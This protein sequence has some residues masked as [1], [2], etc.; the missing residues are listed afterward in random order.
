MPH[1]SIVVTPF[2]NLT[3]DPEEDDFADGLTD[4]LTTDLSRLPGSFVIA[5]SAA[6]AYKGKAI[7][8]QQL[9]VDKVEHLSDL[10][11]LCHAVLR[12]LHI[13]ERNERVW[14]NEDEV[15]PTC[16]VVHEAEGLDERKKLRER[17][18]LR[19]VTAVSEELLPLRHLDQYGTAGGTSQGRVR[20]ASPRTALRVIHRTLL[21]PEALPARG[22]G[23]DL[24]LRGQEGAVWHAHELTLVRGNAHE[25]SRAVVKTRSTARLATECRRAR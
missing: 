3:G 16:A 4:D 10:V 9:G 13:D 23:D 21:E 18:P 17:E 1:L 6:L 24:Q 22:D 19:I 12:R 20:A 14:V 25:L 8:V 2:A 7:D 11:G 5:H 15:A